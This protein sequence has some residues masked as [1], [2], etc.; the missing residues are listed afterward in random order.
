MMREKKELIHVRNY[1]F[2]K[3]S[4]HFYTIAGFSISLMI[5]SKEMISAVRCF[6][7]W[8]LEVDDMFFT[9]RGLFDTGSHGANTSGTKKKRSIFSFLVFVCGRPLLPL[10]PS[11][12]TSPGVST[13]QRQPHNNTLGHDPWHLREIVGDLHLLKPV[14]SRLP[15]FL[16]VGSVHPVDENAIANNNPWGIATPPYK[17]A[18]IFSYVPAIQDIVIINS[19][20]GF[21]SPNVFVPVFRCAS[22]SLDSFI[23]FLV[24]SSFNS[25]PLF[26][27]SFLFPHF[28]PYM[29]YKSVLNRNA[30]RN[31][32]KQRTK[33][34]ISLACI[35]PSNA[36]HKINSPNLIKD[37]NN[38]WKHRGIPFIGLKCICF[39]S[40]GNSST[41]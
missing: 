27:V 8:N 30:V 18:N 4:A 38:A 14:A 24:I 16:R 41:C 32:S 26:L 33:K 23:W 6:G 28:L 19:T 13:N 22:S 36:Y 39:R 37:G 5:F 34:R 15:C 11:K 40:S 2:F 3:K 20:S 17:K 9:K 10:H 21:C 25:S 1:L 29:F 7:G 12:H 35:W 31:D